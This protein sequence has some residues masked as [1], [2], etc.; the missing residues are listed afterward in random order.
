MLQCS[1]N[2]DPKPRA[3]RLP[4]LRAGQDLEVTSDEL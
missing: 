4:R 3:R 2:G 1:V